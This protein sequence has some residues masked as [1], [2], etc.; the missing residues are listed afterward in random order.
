M[1]RCDVTEVVEARCSEK[2]EIHDMQR[3]VTSDLSSMSSEWS[4]RSPC[5]VH[6]SRVPLESV[7]SNL[8]IV[9]LSAFKR[10][11]LITKN[12]FSQDAIRNR[13]RY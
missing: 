4:V 11:W 12:D 5:T 13:L 2:L 3:N 1:L 8:C 10:I 7:V 6:Y 9:G